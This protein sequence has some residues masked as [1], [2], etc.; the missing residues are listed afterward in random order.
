MFFYFY[1]LLQENLTFKTSA[2]GVLLSCID[3]AYKTEHRSGY[4]YPLKSILTTIDA[5]AISIDDVFD[6][7]CAIL[8]AIG[9]N[10]FRFR[11]VN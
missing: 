2:F 6:I 9:W 8:Q 3:I 5:S 1:Y 11:Y 4:K 7:E 10:V